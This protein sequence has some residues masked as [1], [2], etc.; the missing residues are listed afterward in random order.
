MISE[1]PTKVSSKILAFSSFSSLVKELAESEVFA[2]SEIASQKSKNLMPKHRGLD[3][4]KK[5]EFK[6]QYVL[7]NSN[8]VNICTS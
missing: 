8:N 4:A 1:L 5:K 3:A 6:C 2:K 7:I